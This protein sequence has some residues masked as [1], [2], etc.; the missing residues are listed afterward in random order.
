MGPYR[1]L[2]IC[3]TELFIW[4]RFKWHFFAIIIV[5]IIIFYVL[6]GRSK[7]TILWWNYKRKKHY[8]CVILDVHVHSMS[9]LQINA[10]KWPQ[11]N[12]FWRNRFNVMPQGMEVTLR[13]NIMIQF[14]YVINMFRDNEKNLVNRDTNLC[15]LLAP[16][17]LVTILKNSGVGYLSRDAYSLKVNEYKNIKRVIMEGVKCDLHCCLSAVLQHPLH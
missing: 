11:N 4:W 15:K 17:V 9:Q 14:S 2:F 10:S 13:Q 6:K 1:Q 5:N 3:H 16:N 7:N 8:C 12:W